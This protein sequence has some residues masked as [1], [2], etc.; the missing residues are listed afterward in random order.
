MDLAAPKR[1]N[2]APFNYLSRKI[3]PRKRNIAMSVGGDF[4]ADLHG[5]AG[6]TGAARRVDVLTVIR[7]VVQEGIWME[8]EDERRRVE[9]QVMSTGW[10]NRN[11]CI[12]LIIEEIPDPQPI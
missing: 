6:G 8:K 7:E 10:E 3:G 5:E 9:A 1:G 4:L 11:S 12:Y 2:Y